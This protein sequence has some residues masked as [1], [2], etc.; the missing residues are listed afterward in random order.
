MGKIKKA[1]V[2][3]KERKMCLNPALI[4]V[5]YHFCDFTVGIF[6]PAVFILT[7]SEF[8]LRNN[9]IFTYCSTCFI[10]ANIQE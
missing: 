8:P 3:N 10:A 4:R 2:L 5:A 1:L 9:L 6:I 7:C